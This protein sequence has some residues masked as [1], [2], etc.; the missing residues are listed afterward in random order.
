[1]QMPNSSCGWLWN[2]LAL[3]RDNGGHHQLPCSLPSH[4]CPAGSNV[5]ARPDS[6][7]I[8]INLVGEERAE[9]KGERKRKRM[10]GVK[11]ERERRMK[12]KGGVGGIGGGMGRPNGH[13]PPQWLSEGRMPLAWYCHFYSDYNIRC[14]PDSINMLTGSR[15]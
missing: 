15:N 12:R 14:L 9:E 3:K 1:M 7:K 5:S 8:V 2:R 6:E 11:E 10:K 13:Q 4:R